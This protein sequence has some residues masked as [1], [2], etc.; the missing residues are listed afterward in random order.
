MNGTLPL[1][2][3][4]SI[5]ELA[6]IGPNAVNPVYQGAGSAEVGPGLSR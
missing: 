3:S 5:R 6:L 2:P 4:G 1:P